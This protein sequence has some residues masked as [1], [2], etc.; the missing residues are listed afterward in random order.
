MTT[1]CLDATNLRFAYLGGQTILDN[2]SASARPGQLTALI[3]PNGSGK[4][5]LL[6]ILLGLLTPQQGRVI[7]DHTPLK[8]LSERQR[9]AKIAYVPQHASLTFAHLLCDMVALGCWPAGAPRSEAHTELQ[10]WDLG[11]LAQ[12]PWTALSGGERQRGLLARACCQLAQQ[13]RALLVD[14]PTASM[15]PAWAHKT[16]SQLRDRARDRNIAVLAV[17]HDLDLA[18]RYADEVW[19]LAH[20]QLVASGPTREILTTPNLENAYDVP[21]QMIEIEP[22]LTIPLTRPAPRM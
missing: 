10:A 4:T 11:Q 18:A 16:L 14:E 6:R 2:L 15:D 22:G 3:G 7:L 17:L 5:T 13:G 21:F 12:Q 19:L 1:P 9:A 20:G 8:S